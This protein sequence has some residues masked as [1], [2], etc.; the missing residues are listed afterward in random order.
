MTV[1]NYE[2]THMTLNNMFNFKIGNE[3]NLI[4]REV[5]ATTILL[6]IMTGVGERKDLVIKKNDDTSKPN[7]SRTINRDIRNN[8]FII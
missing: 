5:L 1:N 8:N 7:I 4:F 2:Y 6:S 3:N